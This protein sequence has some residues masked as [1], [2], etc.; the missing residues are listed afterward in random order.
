[1]PAGHL[2][3]IIGHGAVNYLGLTR[4]VAK[5]YGTT[6]K[7]LFGGKGLKSNT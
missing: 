4:S 6:V 7:R 5:N 2:P 1:M 3:S